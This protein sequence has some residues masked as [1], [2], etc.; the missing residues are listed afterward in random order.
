[1][2]LTVEGRE[3]KENKE[4][5][6]PQM[7]G[8]EN[9]DA[10]SDQGN[11]LVTPYY[12]PYPKHVLPK[13]GVQPVDIEFSPSSG[14]D[15]SA[16]SMKEGPGSSSSSSSSSSD[17]EQENQVVGEG[18]T[19]DVS[20]ESENRSYDELLKE[21]LK[22]EEELKL[23]N[24][25]LKL[26]E[27]ELKVQIEKS[28]GQLNNAL[29]ELKVKEEDLEYEKG[30]VLELQKKT[31]DL[32]THVPDCSLKIAKLVAQL[33]L[34]EEQ[35]KISDDE[36]ARLEE[37]LNSRSLGTRELQ[38][39]LEVAQDNVAA[40]ENQLDS[41]R[42][43]IHDLEDRVTW[44]KTNETNNE[45]EVQ[46]LKA[47]MLDAQ[48]QFSLEKDQLHSEI[49]HLSEENKQLGS[50]LEEYKSR[51]NIFENK[52]R[53]FEAEKLKLEELLATQQMVLQG[54]ISCLKEELDQRRHDVEAVN[55]EFDRHRQKYDV[56][57]TEKDEANAKIHNL[58]A[59]TRDRDNHIAN[60]EREIIQVCEQKAEL[61]TGSAATLNLVNELKLKVDELEKEVTRQN[62][63]ISDRAEEKR[64]AIRQLCFS[65]EHYRSGYKELLQAFSGH[66]RHAVTA[67]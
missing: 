13:S 24:F 22:N 1:M 53:Q 17:S 12:T 54:E 52:S 38:G 63:V 5:K 16:A 48:A 4:K 26:S 7:E 66:K 34:A 51:S 60:L 20:W 64:E 25:K 27:E 6:E 28:E 30:Q 57:M 41:E 40:L 56:L 10:G 50:R 11:V 9:F 31:A 3:L 65:I 61:I 8:S 47:D 58:M 21:F 23:S 49:A 19:D 44:Y 14:G 18:K 33:E 37:E 43:Q 45:L 46:K 15:S 36:I 2:E 62:A 35:L 42:K 32:E 59:E 39:Q 55:K 67:A 29:V